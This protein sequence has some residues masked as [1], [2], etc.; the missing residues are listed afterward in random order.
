M[1]HTGHVLYLEKAAQLG[2]VLI[3]AV[4]SDDS[5]RKLKGS[6]RPVNSLQDRMRVLASLA[7]VDL[8]VDSVEHERANLLLRLPESIHSSSIC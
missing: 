8:V 1:V 2:D 7:S 6:D 5:V 3:V 4:N